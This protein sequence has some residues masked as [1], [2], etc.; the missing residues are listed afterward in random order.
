MV[1]RIEQ[2]R[3]TLATSGIRKTP[4]SKLVVLWVGSNAIEEAVSCDTRRPF[5]MLDYAPQ[6]VLD[7][8]ELVWILNI[9]GYVGNHQLTVLNFNDHLPAFGH[10]DA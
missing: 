2:R 6:S 9:I 4:R 7:L 10:A 8:G 3:S 1:A 5:K